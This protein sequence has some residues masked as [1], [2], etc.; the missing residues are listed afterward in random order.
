MR[1]EVGS[2]ETRPPTWRTK[3]IQ[4]ESKVTGTAPPKTK[5]TTGAGSKEANGCGDG[6]RGRKRCPGKR[7]SF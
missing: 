7:L 5:G 6:G 3:C 4:E 1:S 2:C